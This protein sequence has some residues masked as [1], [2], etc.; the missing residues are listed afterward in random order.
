[1]ICSQ[2]R[3]VGGDCLSV[4]NHCF[5]ASDIFPFVFMCIFH[6]I[7][8]QRSAEKCCHGNRKIARM[9]MS[10]TDLMAHSTVQTISWPSTAAEGYYFEIFYRGKMMLKLL[11]SMSFKFVVQML[12]WDLLLI[13]FFLK[14]L[15]VHLE[16]QHNSERGLSLLKSLL[17]KWPI[18]QI[19]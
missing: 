17:S 2:I 15:N 7:K 4:F 11:Y 13:K 3:P 16:K 12:P 19:A 14:L 18:F 5:S 8:R 6:T 9:T 1:M 10:E